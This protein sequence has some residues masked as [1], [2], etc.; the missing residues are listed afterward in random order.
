MEGLK[1]WSYLI[2][3]LKDCSSYLG[4]CEEA[5]MRPVP[6]GWEQSGRKENGPNAL[7]ISEA[8]PAEG[9]DWVNVELE[10]KKGIKHEV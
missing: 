9:P 10:G 6:A 2:F 8:E 1:E 4:T 7:W 5:E 3:I